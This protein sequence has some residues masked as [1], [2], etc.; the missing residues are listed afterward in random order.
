[1]PSEGTSEGPQRLPQVILFLD[2]IRDYVRGDVEEFRTQVRRTLLEQV[3]RH[4]GF[5]ED[6]ADQSEP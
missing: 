4:L 3:H 1:M 6:G 5:G 2:N